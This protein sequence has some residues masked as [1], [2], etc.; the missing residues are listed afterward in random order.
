VNPQIWSSLKD[1]RG[2]ALDVTVR[3]AIYG[4]VHRA[5]TDYRWFA[6]SSGFGAFGPSPL[7]HDLALG[8]EDEGSSFYCWRYSPSGAVA[9][10]CYPSRA[11]DAA[12][13]PGVVEK[14]VL[15]AD[16]NGLPP[17]A[18]AFAILPATAALDDNI[19]WNTWRD[20]RWKSLEYHLPI[21]DHECPAIST[22][23]L[24][25]RLDRGVAELLDAVSGEAL[26]QFYAQLLAANGLAVLRMEGT[27]LSPLALAALLLPLDRQTAERVS[28][29]GGVPSTRL[30]A[31]RLA[32]WSGVACPSSVTTSE[33]APASDKYRTMAADFVRKL[34]RSVSR[35]EGHA[36]PLNLSAGG[37]FLLGFL[38]SPELWFAPGRAGK[39]SLASV[40]PWPVVHR[41]EEAIFLR[42]KVKDFIADVESMAM[43]TERRH[44]A[45]KADLLRA[46]L[47]ALCPGS[48]SLDAVSMPSMFVP[49]LLFASRIEVQD[50]E[51]LG[52]Y[53]A[54]EF[55]M[56]ARQSLQA[57]PSL[58]VE[59]ARWLDNC[60]KR[61]DT[62]QAQVYAREALSAPREQ[63]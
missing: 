14:Q 34:E 18:L 20:P 16:A 60:A 12:G 28:L 59:V 9:V 25:T 49:A 51:T 23:D 5:P 7:E 31:S 6:W 39:E 24:D 37:N 50:W 22:A 13:R 35:G 56:L 46:L 2:D 54:V 17:V 44:L 33:V 61:L 62:G 32:H 63:P 11:F 40:G 52:T 57:L 47:L 19:W 26:Q 27:T 38:E 29:A 15:A 1:W 58:A 42:H 10:K 55:Q 53:S 43:G 36:T 48:D 45:T 8:I 3:R 4:K 21:A 30:D 41:E